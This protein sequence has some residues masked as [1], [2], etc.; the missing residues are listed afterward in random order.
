MAFHWLAPPAAGT[1]VSWAGSVSKP[2]RLTFLFIYKE[3]LP[4][5]GLP[6]SLLHPR[7]LTLPCL[8]RGHGICLQNITNRS[9]HSPTVTYLTAQHSISSCSPLQLDFHKALCHTVAR[10][11]VIGCSLENGNLLSSPRFPPSR[12][13][14]HILSRRTCQMALLQGTRLIVQQNRLSIF[15]TKFYWSVAH[16]DSLSSSP[17][18]NL[19]F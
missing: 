13:M 1:A 6:S 12:N 15:I 7:S 19:A 16:R 8:V 10:C 3:Y 2:G 5:S 4:S 17:M 18:M 14:L 9:E 11:Q